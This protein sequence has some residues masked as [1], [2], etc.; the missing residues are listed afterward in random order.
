MF[1]LA[2]LITC[3]LAFTSAVASACDRPREAA[4]VESGASF[5]AIGGGEVTRDEMLAA[6]QAGKPVTFIPADMNHKIARQRAQKR[7]EAEPTDFRG[8]AHRALP[9][10]AAN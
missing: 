8:S 10:G 7:G 2:V 9:K 5:V 6:R 1:H 4:M 3:C